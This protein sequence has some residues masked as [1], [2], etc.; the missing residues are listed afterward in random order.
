MEVI[1]IIEVSIE[2]TKGQY[3][4][5]PPR[6]ILLIG[7]MTNLECKHVYICTFCKYMFIV[8]GE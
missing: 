8:V 3:F 2:A 1:V 6:P 7:L 4:H 5:W